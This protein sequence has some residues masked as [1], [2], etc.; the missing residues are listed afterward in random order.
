MALSRRRRPGRSVGPCGAVPL[1][2]AVSPFNAQTFRE[3]SGSRIAV[4]AQ[5]CPFLAMEAITL[6]DQHEISRF[7]RDGRIPGPSRTQFC[8]RS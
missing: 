3:S 8:S 2:H 1:N 5:K 4:S 6:D 7:V